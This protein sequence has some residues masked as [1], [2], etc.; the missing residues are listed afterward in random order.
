MIRR[1]C[2]ADPDAP[3]TIWGSGT[4][5]REFLHVDDMATAC[6]FV[7]ALPRPVWE[8]VTAPDRRFLNVGAGEDLSILELARLVAQSAG[9]EGKIHTDPSRPDGTPRKLLDTRRLCGLGWQPRVGLREGIA[10]T[11]A[12]YRQHGDIRRPARMMAT[13]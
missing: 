7:M 3:V 9:H 10:A 13:P 11:L 12:W 4:P 2:R 1:F 6:L 5:R 8:G